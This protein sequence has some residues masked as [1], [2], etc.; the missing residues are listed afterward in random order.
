LLEEKNKLLGSGKQL[1]VCP[2]YANLSS[3]Q[4]MLAFEKSELRKVV[5]STNIA[6][7]SVTI[8]GIKFVIDSGLCK[9]RSFKN[10]TGVDSLQVTAIS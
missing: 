3:E 9:Q 2:L 6:E 10:T 1:K 8:S 7:T 4:Q 5:L